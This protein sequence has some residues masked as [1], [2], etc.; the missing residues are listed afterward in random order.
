MKSFTLIHSQSSLRHMQCIIL[1]TRVIIVFKTAS[2]STFKRS[3]NG[4]SHGRQNLEMA[5]SFITM[6]AVTALMVPYSFRKI[7]EYLEMSVVNSSFT[8]T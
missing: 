5:L 2:L 6:V 3:A 7:S 1:E 4:T 8:R